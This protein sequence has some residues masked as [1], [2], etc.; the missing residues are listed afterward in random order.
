MFVKPG[1]WPV[2]LLS[3]MKYA[4]SRTLPIGVESSV[5]KQR[6]ARGTAMRSPTTMSWSGCQPLAVRKGW[7]PVTSIERPLRVVTLKHGLMPLST[8]APISLGVMRPSEVKLW[9]R[10]IL[11]LTAS[12]IVI[13]SPVAGSMT[14]LSFLTHFPIAGRP[15]MMIR[16]D[17]LNPPV[18]RSRSWN[19]DGTPTTPCPLSICSEMRSMAGP[20]RSYSLASSRWSRS[21]ATPNTS[22]C[23]WLIASSASTESS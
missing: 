7:W 9:M 12:S 8:H 20:S 2:R 6:T 10:G 4:S 19:P 13:R 16:S 5:P 14:R 17:S 15:A 21:S 22:D 11:C 1:V 18:M 3:A 23:A